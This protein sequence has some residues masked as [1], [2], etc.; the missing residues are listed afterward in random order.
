MNFQSLLLILVMFDVQI[1]LFVYLPFTIFM[2]KKTP[3]ALKAFGLETIIVLLKQDARTIHTTNT[4][5]A[6]ET[7]NLPYAEKR[8]I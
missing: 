5:N 4:A 7:C 3:I 6:L 2:E 1:Q 8:H